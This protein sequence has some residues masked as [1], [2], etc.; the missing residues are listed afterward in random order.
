MTIENNGT[1]GIGTVSPDYLLEVNGTA[2]KPGGGSWTNT[3]DL[4]LKQNIHPYTDGL[5]SILKINPIT[6]QYNELSGHDTDPEY[7]GVIAQELKEIA[8]YMVSVSNNKTEDGV[9]D[10]LSVD[11]SAMTYMLINAV[12][13][14]QKM[15]DE[16]KQEIQILKEKINPK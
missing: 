13:E 11:N 15:I 2:G 8:P 7:V 9:N 5:Q 16:L 10:Y 6:Y 14:Q 12:K 4:R 1:V 3:S